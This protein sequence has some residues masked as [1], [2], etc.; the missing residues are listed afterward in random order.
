MGQVV[1]ADQLRDSIDDAIAAKQ[2][3][4]GRAHLGASLIG[5]ACE[6]HLWYVFGTAR[7]LST[8]VVCCACSSAGSVKKQR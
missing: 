2:N 1:R 3:A 6:R 8:L 5:H 7:P 4:R